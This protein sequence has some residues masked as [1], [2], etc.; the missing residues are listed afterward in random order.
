ML[1]QVVSCC[2]SPTEKLAWLCT[3]VLSP[4]FDFV[5]S[6]LKNTHDHLELLSKLLYSQLKVWKFCSGDVSS[7]LKVQTGIFTT[8]A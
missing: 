8:F 6:H 7:Q 3:T 5:L 4:L 1:S 2:G